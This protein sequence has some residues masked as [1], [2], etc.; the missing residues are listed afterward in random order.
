VNV[1]MLDVALD[2]Q[3]QLAH[4]VKGP[5]A[6]RLLR[7][8]PEPALD[9]VE[10]ARVRRCEVHVIA[11]ALGQPCLDLGVLVSRI[12]V[13][14]HVDVQRCGNGLINVV[15]KRDELLVSMPGLALRNDLT[16]GCVE[17]SEQRSGAVTNVIMR[18][19]LYVAQAHG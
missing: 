14:D 6:D 13:H 10:P 16:S 18:D 3:N 8:Q 5:A 7:D 11:R 9:L 1:V 2:L 15:Q 12:V 17:C 4:A 19:T